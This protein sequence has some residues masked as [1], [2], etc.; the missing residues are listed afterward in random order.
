VTMRS[1]T[2]IVTKTCSADRPARPARD[3]GAA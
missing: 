2:L 3:P 1:I